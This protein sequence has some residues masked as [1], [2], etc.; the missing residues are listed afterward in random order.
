MA[1]S[2]SKSKRS[3]R[4]T[5]RFAAAVLVI[6]SMLLL[7]AAP[8]LTGMAYADSSTP[9]AANSC[10][11]GYLN[12]NDWI[13]INALIVLAIMAISG[14]IYA[15]GGVVPGRSREK[16]IGIA[17]YEFIE[18]IVGLLIIVFLVSFSSAICNFS[19]SI[20]QSLIGVSYNQFQFS[21]YYVGSLLFD[22][23]ATILTEL[24]STSVQF[25]VLGQI[26]GSVGSLLE[27]T[28]AEGSI[29]YVMVSP[30]PS[31]ELMY[32]SY[33]SVFSDDFAGLMLVSFG[34]LFLLFLILPI[35]MAISLTVLVPVA[36]A[37]R[38]VGFAGPRLREAANSFLALG[39]ALYFIF[40]M[41]IIF[42]AYVVSWMYCTGI[43][44][45]SAP[46]CLPSNL[47]TYVNTYQL[48][49]LP[50]GQLFSESS[51]A[52]SGNGLLGGF[53][54]SSSMYSTL[55]S[56]LPWQDLLAAPTGVTYFGNIVAEYLFEGILL[57]A[58]DFAITIGFAIGLTKGLNSLA[59][60][61]TTG[62]FW[63]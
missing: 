30:S 59:N 49:T 11:Y 45:V 51:S 6:A 43:N 5:G 63:G 14:V 8:L 53:K 29:A 13:S 44:G 1:A 32:I 60:L 41:T 34:G 38:S 35:I 28:P 52:V 46:S 55:F 24:Y 15:L 10:T 16:F 25:Y 4:H 50:T 42:N 23:G 12:Q 18:G 20:S 62:P 22:K 36:I 2:I 17:K 21:Q 58:L 9:T 27:Q 54:L 7:I 56:G 31:L 19:S 3:G 61:I 33:S 47:R 48:N 40:P 57:V 39:I 26:V 37:M